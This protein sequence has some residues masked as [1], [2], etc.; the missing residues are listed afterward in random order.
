MPTHIDHIIHTPWTTSYNSQPHVQLT[1]SARRCMS[2]TIYGLCSYTAWSGRRHSCQVRHKAAT[3][4]K[5]PCNISTTDTPNQGVGLQLHVCTQSCISSAVGEHD[6]AST[7]L[8]REQHSHTLLRSLAT[9]THATLHGG[10]LTHIALYQDAMDT[11]TQS[12]A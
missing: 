2:S 10:G 11:M 12:A 3:K 4:Q 6:V 8:S 1:L 9:D 7:V 5:P